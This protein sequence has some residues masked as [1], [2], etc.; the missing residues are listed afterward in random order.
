MSKKKWKIGIF[1]GI[2]LITI[3][4]SLITLPFLMDENN[5]NNS[6]Q[7]SFSKLKSSENKM[8]D[9][10]EQEKNEIATRMNQF[11]VYP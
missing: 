6:Y 9:L 10:I 11:N 2:A 4:G 8:L 7:E 1:L 3:T 5:S